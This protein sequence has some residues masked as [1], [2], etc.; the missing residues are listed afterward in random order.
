MLIILLVFPFTEFDGYVKGI[1]LKCSPIKPIPTYK[2]N[3]GFNGCQC[4]HMT[5]LDD[6]FYL[7]LTKTMGLSFIDFSNSPSMLI[8]KLGDLLVSLLPLGLKIQAFWRKTLIKQA[9]FQI[10]LYDPSV[11]TSGRVSNS[12]NYTTLYYVEV[13]YIMIINNN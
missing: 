13:D 4:S 5:Y 7:S 6:I 8:H 3:F 2:L 10:K 11:S 9:M 1:K 12:T